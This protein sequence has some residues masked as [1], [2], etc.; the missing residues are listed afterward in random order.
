MPKIKN[1]EL[2]GITTNYPD[3]V[4]TISKVNRLSYIEHYQLDNNQFRANTD[5]VLIPCDSN[6]NTADILMSNIELRVEHL[7]DKYQDQ[8]QFD[9]YD[10]MLD[11]KRLQHTR[12]SKQ[13]RIRKRVD[14]LLWR[15]CLWLT[16]TFSDEFLAKHN[17]QT[18]RRYIK[19]YLDSLGCKYIANIDYGDSI[20]Y[21][22][23]EHYH[24]IAQIDKVDFKAYRDI[25][26]SSISGKKITYKCGDDLT[27]YIWKLTNHC[28]KLSTN[29]ERILCNVKETDLNLLF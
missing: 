21:T 13:S 22:G 29:C 1:P 23:R 4:N 19:R 16:L 9:K 7:T 2:R 28:V 20:L 25:F 14:Y 18:R 5:G 15:D 27:E 11:F 8:A 3:I 24:A 12:A 17:K 6:G 26:D 10:L